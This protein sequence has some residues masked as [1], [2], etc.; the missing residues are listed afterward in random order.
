ME[1][2]WD[3]LDTGM[4]GSHGGPGKPKLG[5]WI[6]NLRKEQWLSKGRKQARPRG[7]VAVGLQEN[8]SLQG[9]GTV[10]GDWM[11][12]SGSD[13]VSENEDDLHPY[14]DE[15]PIR[16]RY[17]RGSA[18][19]IDDKLADEKA[20]KVLRSKVYARTSKKSQATW[21]KW[22]PRRAAAR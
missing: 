4:P 10:T 21:R 15:A 19:G 12:D 6:K 3:F 5:K 17:T 9:D 8:P 11:G 2:D 20:V 22:W 13:S 1:P 18:D 16:R 14:R 7:S